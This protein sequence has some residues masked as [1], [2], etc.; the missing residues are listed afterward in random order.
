[1]VYFSATESHKKAV[2]E[3]A[4]Y[5]LVLRPSLFVVLLLRV[6]LIPKFIPQTVSSEIA[7]L[8]Y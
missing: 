7:L 3:K 6:A 2:M 1:M 4:L 8:P 5:L